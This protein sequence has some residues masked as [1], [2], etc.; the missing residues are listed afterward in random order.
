MIQKKKQEHESEKIRLE[1]DLFFKNKQ[2]TTNMLCMNK[3]NKIK[4]KKQ[5]FKKY[6]KINHKLN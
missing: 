6:Q 2:K 3:K 4:I 5:R 1:K